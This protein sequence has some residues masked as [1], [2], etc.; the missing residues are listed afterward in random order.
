MIGAVI[1]FALPG[2]LLAW[3][4]ASGRRAAPA[5]ALVAFTIAQLSHL[6]WLVLGSL[7]AVLLLATRRLWL[8]QWLRLTPFLRG[9]R[10]RRWSAAGWAPT[11]NAVGL[12]SLRN[13][14]LAPLRIL[15]VAEVIQA[16]WTLPL[17]VTVSDVEKERAALA[18][19]FDAPRLDIVRVRP[20][21]VGLTWRW[22]EPLAESRRL[23]EPTPGTVCLADGF[24]I[25][26]DE[27]GEDVRWSPLSPPSH[28]L[29]A[30]GTRSGKSVALQTLLAQAASMPDLQV[31]GI[32]PTGILLAPFESAPDG[33]QL[34][35]G[36]APEALQRAVDVLAHLVDVVLVERLQHLR[37]TKADALREPS[38]E[39]PVLLVVLEEYPA[40]LAACSA[41]DTAAARK[42]QDRLRVRVELYV[43]R[44]LAEGLKAAI[45]VVLAAQRADADVLGGYRRDQM[46]TRIG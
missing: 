13:V 26:R 11:V 33:E 41:D 27:S 43:Q 44:L 1:A 12:G 9:W 37:A 30:G 3:S 42:P 29:V 2:A 10:V 34:A 4:S 5:L 22:D 39:H 6:I 25:G 45:V 31:C 8:G 46:S 15:A 17:G 18:A 36:T 19:F 7:A 20:T 32:D 23:D 38:T 14:P 24:L 16:H 21:V 35:C 40:L 28:A